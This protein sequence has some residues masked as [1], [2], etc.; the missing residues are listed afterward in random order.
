[1]TIPDRST[2][3]VAVAWS[4]EGKEE[5]LKEGNT[6]AETK[7]MPVLGRVIADPP[8]HAQQCAGLTSP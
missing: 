7:C 5:E 8:N 6:A 1:M 2:E 4:E 3:A